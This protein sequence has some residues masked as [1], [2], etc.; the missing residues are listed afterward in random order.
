M[1]LF[2]I[3]FGQRSEGWYKKQMSKLIAKRN[4]LWAGQK[5][6]TKNVPHIPV[7]APQDDPVT[8]T[9]RRAYG[10]NLGESL[11]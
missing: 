5:K 10:R 3:I 8:K 6:L 1:G 9:Y 4:E 11:F 2:D 7:N